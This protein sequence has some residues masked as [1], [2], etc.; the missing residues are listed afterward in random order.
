M[1]SRQ[2]VILAPG[3]LNDADLWRD[4]IVA[5][6][7]RYDVRVA[8]I[9]GSDRLDVL[10]QTL[11]DHAPARF[12]L[13][14][15][16][17]GGYVAQQVVR[18]APGRVERL[19]LL[20]TSCRAETPARRQRRLDMD[21]VA[22]LPGRFHGFGEGMVRHY[23][24][25]AHADDPVLTLRVRAM[26]ERLGAEVFLR[27]NAI[28]RV[29]GEAVIRAFDGP[30]L[31]LCGGEDA[32]TSPEGHREMAA[33]AQDSELVILDGCGHLTPLEAPR[34][35]SAALLRWLDR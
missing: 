33:M 21:Q 13:A 6:E 10:A 22:R 28:E 32:V 19:A 34:E 4:Q 27:Q 23:V 15:F 5:L 2:T 11:L 31:V 18:M 9:S 17:L 7:E 14:G 30:V 16:S 12:S 25:S 1:T 35:V 24:G 8:D 29:D 26:T 3:M 20:D